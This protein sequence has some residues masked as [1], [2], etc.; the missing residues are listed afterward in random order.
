[1]AKKLELSKGNINISVER[2]EIIAKEGDY[3]LEQ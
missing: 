1:L 3:K 2:G